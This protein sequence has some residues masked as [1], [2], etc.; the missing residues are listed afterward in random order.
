MD[1]VFFFLDRAGDLGVIFHAL[2]V[3]F[4]TREAISCACFRR[5]TGRSS[6]TAGHRPATAQLESNNP[7]GK[8]GQIGPGSCPESADVAQETRPAATGKESARLRQC[9]V[10][11]DS[12]C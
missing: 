8:L 9:L 11:T 7:E 4:P 2:F 5:D 1:W 6:L 12:W 3:Q 10:S